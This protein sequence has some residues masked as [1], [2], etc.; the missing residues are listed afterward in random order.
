MARGSV[1][2]RPRWLWL[3]ASGLLLLI[4]VDLAQIALRVASYPSFLRWPGASRYL[5]PVILALIG[6]SIWIVGMLALAPRW[7]GAWGAL[8]VGTVIGLVGGCMEITGITIE[9]LLT[10]PQPVV[11]VATLFAMLALFALFGVAGF[12]GARRARV[13][14]PGLAAALWSAIV[15]AIIAVTFGFLLMSLALPQLARGMVG[16][17][18]YLRSGW[19]DPA[20][21]A[22]ANTLDNG[23]SHLLM[24]PG[25]AAALGGLGAVLALTLGRQRV[26]TPA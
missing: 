25:I 9:S 17:P 14:W 12:A 26:T 2:R 1:A 4:V 21:F 6:Y 11:S 15:A 13:F 16:D 18:D 24:A 19:T 5:G 23:V 20:A 7:R 22:I 8:G 3:I 10:L